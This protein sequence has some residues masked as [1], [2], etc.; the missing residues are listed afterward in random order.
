MHLFGIRRTQGIGK[1][2]VVAGI[3]HHVFQLTAQRAPCDL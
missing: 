1:T 2:E 3:Q